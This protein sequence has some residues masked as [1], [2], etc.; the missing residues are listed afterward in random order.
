MAL[1]SVFVCIQSFLIEYVEMLGRLGWP[2][3][4][5]LEMSCL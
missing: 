1:S 5:V 2:E 3:S 4:G